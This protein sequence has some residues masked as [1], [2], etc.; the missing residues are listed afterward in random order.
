MIKEER[1]LRAHNRIFSKAGE[2]V[3]PSHLSPSDMMTHLTLHAKVISYEV[4]L[5]RG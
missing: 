5:D 2:L 4:L 3:R 1:C